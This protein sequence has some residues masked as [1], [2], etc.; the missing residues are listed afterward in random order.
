METVDEKPAY[1]RPFASRRCLLPADGDFSG[2]PPSSEREGGKPAEA[3]VLHLLRG[4]GRPPWPALQDLQITRPATRT[5]CSVRC[6]LTVHQPPPPRTPSATS[7]AACATRRRERASA[8]LDPTGGSTRDLK[9]GRCCRPGRLEASPGQQVRSTASAT[10]G[11]S[12]SSRAP[13]SRPA[14]RGP[15]RPTL[16]CDA[17]LVRDRSRTRSRRC[18]SATAPAAASRRPNWPRRPRR[19]RNGVSV[20]RVEQP[21]RVAG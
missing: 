13:P 8:G 4:C 3:A 2:T 19:G 7:T 1:R 11:P 15:A 14:Q 17:R 16:Y 5:T 21:W 6:D 10:N 9:A 20:V 18:C 12:W